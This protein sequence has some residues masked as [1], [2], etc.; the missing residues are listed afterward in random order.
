M[1]YLLSV[2]IAFN[3]HNYT[4]FLLLLFT[5][6]GKIFWSIS[7]GMLVISLPGDFDLL[8]RVKRGKLFSVKVTPYELL[9]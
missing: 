1:P 4:L 9:H 8:V 2:S 3:A 7:I 6:S 5:W